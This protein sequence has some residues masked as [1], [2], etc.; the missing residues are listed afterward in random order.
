MR[1]RMIRRAD[2]KLVAEA[3]CDL[4][5]K[6]TNWKA[7][8]LAA[9]EGLSKFAAEIYG[10]AN[11]DRDLGQRLRAASRDCSGHEPSLSLLQM[12]ADEA[13]DRL[14]P[15]GETRAGSN[16]ERIERG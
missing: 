15:L 16:E 2:A 1:E 4:A 7:R 5:E 12:T 11:T 14:A 13:A 6:A 9:E 3:A 8:A 10:T